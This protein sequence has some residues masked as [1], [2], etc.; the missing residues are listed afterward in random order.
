MFGY[1][2]AVDTCDGNS[3]GHTGSILPKAR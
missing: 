1:Q 3:P 2:D